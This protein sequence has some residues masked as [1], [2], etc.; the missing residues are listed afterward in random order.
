MSNPESFIDEVTEELRRDRL[1][2]LLRRYGWIAVAAVLLIV[3]G[4]SYFEWQKARET[5]Q[6]RALGDAILTAME[7]DTPQARLD[8][9]AGV[10]ATGEA[11]VLVALLTAGE[12]LNAENS[13]N[14]QAQLQSVINDVSIAESYRQFATVKLVMLQGDS[15]APAQRRTALEPLIEAGG[16]FRTIALEQMALISAEEG[17]TEG[18]IDL[19]QQAASSSDATADLRQR[20]SQLIVALGGGFDAGQ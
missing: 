3:G 2:K 18:A 20:V 10:D 16:P 5:A 17:D 15:V 8:A 4:A 1:Y 14:A 13:E 11:R 19:L 6:A 7:Q 12:E 9:L